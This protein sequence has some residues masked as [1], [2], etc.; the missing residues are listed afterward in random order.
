MRV[1]GEEGRMWHGGR[2]C[3]LEREGATA[4]VRCGAPR[5]YLDH[6][7][8]CNL[9]VSQ[10]ICF[11]AFLPFHRAPGSFGH[12]ATGDSHA[13]VWRRHRAVQA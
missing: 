2:G 5:M 13:G 9:S 11:L 1:V 10:G 3:L 4:T 12:G 8:E 7:L 6:R